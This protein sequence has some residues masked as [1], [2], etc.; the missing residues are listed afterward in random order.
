MQYEKIDYIEGHPHPWRLTIKWKSMPA[1]AF[2]YY[3]THARAQSF[4]RIPTRRL[5]TASM[6]QLVRREIQ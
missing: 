5:S 6:R 2:Y 4:L 3:D 1:P